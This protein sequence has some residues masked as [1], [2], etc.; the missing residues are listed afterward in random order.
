MIEEVKKSL[1]NLVYQ[2]LNLCL[3][4]STGCDLKKGGKSVTPRNRGVSGGA[5]GKWRFLMIRYLGAFL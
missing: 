4:I 5:V 1:H 2:T 3:G